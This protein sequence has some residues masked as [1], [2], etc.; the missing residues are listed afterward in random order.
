MIKPSFLERG[1]QPTTIFRIFASPVVAKGWT[2]LPL[3]EIGGWGILTWLAGKKHPD[4]PSA[5]QITAGT[6]TTLILFGSEW[7]HN[8]AHAAG[9]KMVGKPVD[10]IRIFYGTPLLIYYDIN[11]SQVLPEEHIARSLG[12]PIFNILMVPL[13][14]TG[15]QF[16]REGTFSRYIADFAFGTNVFISA[17]SLVPIPGID[18][19][20]LLKWSLVRM[21][22]TVA[23][24]DETVRRVN[25]VVGGGLAVTAGIAAKKKR[26]WLATLAGALAF[27]SLAIGLGIL[28]EQK[29]TG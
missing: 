3:L 5:R 18:G 1:D 7:C 21:G 28:K 20:P 4:W 29:L 24:A 6:V 14:W 26:K 17:V 22:Q 2:G 16:T 10:A 13:A 25:L 27:T 9:A 15:R 19:G 11:D 12:G 8:L 23:G